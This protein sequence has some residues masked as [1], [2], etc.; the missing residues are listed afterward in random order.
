M[1][2]R[3]GT[4]FVPV[5]ASRIMLSLKKLSAQPKTPWCLETLTAAS[6]GRSTEDG[7][8][9]LTLRLPG[10]QRKTPQNSMAPSEEGVELDGVR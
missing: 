3:A 6:H 4:I 5:M 1:A 8:V 7:V 9:H 10:R 2:H